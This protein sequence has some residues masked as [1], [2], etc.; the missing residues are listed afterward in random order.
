LEQE[1][2]NMVSSLS[3][4]FHMYRSCSWLAFMSHPSIILSLF[5]ERK[6]VTFPNPGLN[7]SVDW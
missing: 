7:F 5:S 3:I 4:S 6:P 2:R 1:D